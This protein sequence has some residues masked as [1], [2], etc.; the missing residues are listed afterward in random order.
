MI[1]NN[2]PTFHDLKNRNAVKDLLK[3]HQKYLAHTPDEQ[4]SAHMELVGY[5][6]LKLV[7]AHR[8]EPLIDKL[9][10]KL[11]NGDGNL[12]QI[13]KRLFWDVILY[14][15]F[16][17]VNENFQK[18][19]MENP[20]FPA[21]VRNGIDSQHSI[22]SAF[23]FLIHQYSDGEIQKIANGDNKILTLVACF[24]HN[25]AR[26][27]S[28]RLKDLSD[29]ESFEKFRTELCE[30]L[31][32]YL[33]LFKRDVYPQL[34]QSLPRI[35]QSLQIENL[36]FEWFLLLRLNF[37]LLTA[38][39]YYAT[40]HFSGKWKQHYKEFGTLYSEQKQR[41][42][43]NLLKTQP[44]NEVLYAEHKDLLSQPLD[45]LQD[46]SN[47]N[48]NM[49]RSK[50]AAEVLTNV[51]NHSR[52]RLFYIEAPTGGGKT[53]MA[54]IVT[55]ELILKNQELNKVFYVF[56]FTTLITQTKKSAEKTLGLHPDELMELHS[57]AAFKEK[58]AEQDGLYGKDRLDDIHNQFVNYPYTFLSHVR[59][60][61]ILK[62]NDKN[63]IYLLHRLANSV[64]VID[65]VQAYNPMLWDKM[66]YLL[67]EYAESLNI[68]FVIMSATLPK[69]GELAKAEFNYLI[70]NAV[71]RYFTNPNF[72]QRV[73]FS[74]EFL[75]RGM[76]D[77]N[78]RE[79]YMQ[80]LALS[81]FEKTDTYRQNHGKV[82]AIVEFI[83]KK[84]STEFAEL[85][86]TVFKDYEIRVLSGTI[87]EPRRREI[88]NE[89]KNPENLNS[90]V[91]LITTQVVEAGV[92]IDMD[93]GFKNRSII[94]SDEQLAGRV[95]RNVNKQDCMVFLFDLDDASVIY[96][97]DLRFSEWKKGLEKNHLEILESKRFDI[98]Y[99]RVKKYL[100]ESNQQNLGGNLDSFQRL[101]IGS[102]NFPEVDNEFKLIDHKNTS[103][104]V[105]FDLPL[106]ILG[107]SGE[108]EPVFTEPQISFLTEHGV[109][110]QNDYLSGQELFDLY[111]NLLSDQS[112]SFI[113]RKRN[114]RMLQSLMSMFTFSLF[115]E[116]RVTKDLENGGNPIEYGYMYLTR[117]AEVYDYKLGLI[118]KQ[119]DGLIFI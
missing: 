36:P 81:I 100:D 107:E 69:I 116:S 41:H 87:L 20:Q 89:L 73:K 70:T 8:L 62:T 63:S 59:F 75:S 2:L 117:H 97:K 112:Q 34:V 60:F 40:A 35:S 23:I 96:K 13:G 4:L 102:L 22:L 50:M 24:A 44:H 45:Q 17:K 47:Q 95:N 51:R 115:S 58:E 104:F 106:T 108:A 118:D 91:L 7:E 32:G 103:V 80:W 25:I 49:L 46:K 77:K 79:D 68:R 27:H 12:A 61:D 42:F 111:K 119:L 71:E 3:E 88:I 57:R 99:N 92:D 64:V 84:S 14:H 56:P 26:H 109:E 83:F 67:K 43:K 82:R 9:F 30:S 18:Q 78:E 93:L 38:A 53:N 90:N 105:P 29:G 16:G 33:S 98:L 113:A 74:D 48:L 1:M 37:S 110:V 11:A 28:K 86:E 65:E 15:D 21:A 54:F 66:A 19:R 76:P 6:F 72:A 94:D 10:L 55:Q 31:Q 52:E 101:L 39:D 5:Y 114:L 85:A